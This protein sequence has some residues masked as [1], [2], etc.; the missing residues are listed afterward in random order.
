[1]KSEKI[2]QFQAQ[3]RKS[4]KS[5]KIFLKIRQIVANQ[6]ILKQK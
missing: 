1:L 5:Q 2:N 4:E 6:G 3:K